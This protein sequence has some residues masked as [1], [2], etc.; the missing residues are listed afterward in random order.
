M[1][2]Y[3]SFV[4]ISLNPNSLSNLNVCKMAPLMLNQFSLMLF[5]FFDNSNGKVSGVY[6]WIKHLDYV[7]PARSADDLQNVLNTLDL[8]KKYQYS[9]DT[10]QYNELKEA[11]VNA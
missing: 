4:D 3:F 2:V 7:K 1:I 9:F 8:T 6:E 5:I 10:A 11:L